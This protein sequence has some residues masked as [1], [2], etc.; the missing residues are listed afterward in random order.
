MDTNV[1]NCFQNHYLWHSE[2]TL[3]IYD[4]YL[5]TLWIAF[6]IIIFDIRK[7]PYQIQAD[8]NARCEL[9]SKSLSLTFGNNNV[10][11]SAA[12]CPVVNCFQNHY[13]WHS[14]TTNN[15]PYRKFKRCELLSKSLSLTFGNNYVWCAC[16][17]N[18][19]V[20]CFQNHYLWHS[21]TTSSCT[22]MQGWTLWI[23]F[24][25]IIF[26]IRKQRSTLI[27]KLLI[28]CEL[29]SKSLSLTFGNNRPRS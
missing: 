4:A 20:N 23:A 3:I 1:V 9:L 18:H 28:G 27:E 29:L 10:S 8:A 21:E 22:R 26:D 5:P 14:E 16:R 25:I 19:V 11:A 6:K 17:H 7:Q 15:Y 12:E 2:T 13:L 24:K